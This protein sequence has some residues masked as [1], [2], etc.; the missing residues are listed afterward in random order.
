MARRGWIFSL[1]GN[2]IDVA[3]GGTRPGMAR[4]GVLEGFSA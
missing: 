2:R 4:S 1:V 3:G